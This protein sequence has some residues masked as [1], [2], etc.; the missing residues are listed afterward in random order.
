MLVYKHVNPPF[1]FLIRVLHTL[2]HHKGKVVLATPPV[3]YNLGLACG[4]R[5]VCILLMS[6][7]KCSSIT[8]NFYNDVKKV[9]EAHLSFLWEHKMNVPVCFPW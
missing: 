4:T 8:Y 1:T 2:I 3:C 6:M 7:Y 9:N 5:P